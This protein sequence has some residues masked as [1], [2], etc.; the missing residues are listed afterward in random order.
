M[1][2]LHVCFYTVAR[3]KGRCL[4]SGRNGVSLSWLT[5]G[6]IGV[7]VDLER[8]NLSSGS[9]GGTVPASLPS[10]P[11]EDKPETRLLLMPV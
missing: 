10:I 9:P 6:P 8:F 1:L 7:N 11:H 4:E 2:H 5:G 3:S